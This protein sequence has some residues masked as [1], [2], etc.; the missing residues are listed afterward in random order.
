MNANRVGTETSW[1]ALEPNPLG[2]DTKRDKRRAELPEAWRKANGNRRAGL[3]S[4]PAVRT[5][6]AGKPRELADVRAEAEKT[7]DKYWRHNGGPGNVPNRYDGEHVTPWYRLA[8]ASGHS[9]IV[10]R[11]PA[12]AA[13]DA[14]IL[15]L[16]LDPDTARPL[17]LITADVWRAYSRVRTCAP[18]G[19]NSEPR[20]TWKFMWSGIEL[21]ACDAD[22]NSAREFVDAGTEIGAGDAPVEID[23]SDTLVW[24]LRGR[25]YML[26]RSP[27]DGRPLLFEDAG[28]V[29]FVVAPLGRKP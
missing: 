17:A 10:E 6:D 27:S 1:Y 22:G 28:A 24:P 12:P 4:M 15:K 16:G 26:K 18:D 14:K 2:K 11:A 19:P 25:P 13:A 29:A 8:R 21:S 3:P 20:V 7:I 23:L 5:V 9:A